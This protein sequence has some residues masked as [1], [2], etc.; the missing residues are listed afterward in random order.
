MVSF[1]SYKL[2]L[3]ILLKSIVPQPSLH[4][5]WLNTLSFLENCG[6]RLLAACEHPTKVKSEMLK[7]ASEEFRHAYYLKQQIK[8]ISAE[9]HHSYECNLILGEISSLHYLRALNVQTCRYLKQRNC[10]KIREYSYLLVTY[11]IEMRAQDLYPLYQEILKQN[12]SP[13]SVNSILREEEQH[14]SD[15]HAELLLLEDHQ[16]M[17]NE[18]CAFENHLCKKWIE[19]IHLSCAITPRTAQQ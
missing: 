9:K 6:A 1:I 11:A 5:K 2:E 19:R 13:V 3:E 7:H 12:N 4:A 10:G 14:L 18:I 17:M 16:E 15:I 8:K